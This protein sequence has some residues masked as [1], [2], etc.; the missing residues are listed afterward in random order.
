VTVA[1]HEGASLAGALVASGIVP[2]ST[3]WSYSVPHLPDGVYTAEASQG[4]EAGHTGT[5]GA[6]HFT[7]DTTP[8]KLTMET[9]EEGVLHT[10]QPIF[11]GRAGEASGDLPLVTLRIYEGSGARKKL[12]GAPLEITPAGG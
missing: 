7:V 11:S 10:S 2:A 3:A 8:P 4:D 5:S 1:I 9:P 12:L 6:V